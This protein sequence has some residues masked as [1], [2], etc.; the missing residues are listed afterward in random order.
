[1][2]AELSST[3]SSPPAVTGGGKGLDRPPRAGPALALFRRIRQQWAFWPLAVVLAVAVSSLAILVVAGIPCTRDITI[4]EGS[5]VYSI[6]ACAEGGSLYRDYRRPPYATTPYTPLYYLLAALPVRLAGTRDAVSTAYFSGRILTLLCCLLSLVMVGTLA[7]RAG[8][9]RPGAFCAALLLTT[10]PVLFLFGISCRPDFLALALT[11]AG[12]SC[13]LARPTLGGTLLTSACFTAAFFAKQ[14]FVAGFLAVFLGCLLRGSWKLA[15][16]LLVCQL[17]GTMALSTALNV[18]TNGL[19]YANVVGANVAP[20]AWEQPF[21][22]FG[23]FYLGQGALVVFFGVVG[24]RRL[25]RGRGWAN[26]VLPLYA[27]LALW[28]ATVAS[29]KPGADHNYFIEPLFATA[30]LAGRGLSRAW[31]LVQHR[32]YVRRR[33]V[34]L[35]L[36]LSVP[37]IVA[38]VHLAVVSPTIAVPAEQVLRALDAVPGDILFG[39]AGLAVRSGRPVLLLDKFNCAYLANAGQLDPAELIDR[40]QRHEI[41]AVLLDQSSVNETFNGQVWWPPGVAQAV[42]EHYRFR[43]VIHGQYLYVPATSMTAVPRQ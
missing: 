25:R 19:Y 11:L 18:W 35:T 41:A 13:F 12:L 36:V 28:L 33:F 16:T 2:K 8:A 24:L 38:L 14:S 1:M 23:A 17:V 27:V 26:I 42:A 34:R 9:P 31:C 32:P 15:G 10:C 21:R 5:I 3:C 22:F 40:L 4:P 43:E 30:I 6:K 7:R 29:V 39:D 20:P 37:M